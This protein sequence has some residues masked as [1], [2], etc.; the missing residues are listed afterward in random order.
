MTA[1]QASCP[2]QA[3]VFGDIEDPNTQVSQ[4]KTEPHNFSVLEEVNTRPRA[5]YL[6]AVRNKNSEITEA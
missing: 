4:L 1:C 3:I 2:T 6:G 5:S